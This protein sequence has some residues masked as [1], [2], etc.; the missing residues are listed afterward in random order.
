[1]NLRLPGIGFIINLSRKAH[2]LGLAVNIALR[3][4]YSPLGSLNLNRGNI[5]KKSSS[6]NSSAWSISKAP[7]SHDLNLSISSRVLSP[8]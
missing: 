1:M 2:A 8:P 4:G 6:A 3:L 5:I 7:N